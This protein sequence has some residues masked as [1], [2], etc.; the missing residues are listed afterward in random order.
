MLQI[1]VNRAPATIISEFTRRTVL[2]IFLSASDLV[3]KRWDEFLP[4]FLE[5][6]H[7]EIIPQGWI[8]DKTAETHLSVRIYVKVA[9][10]RD[11]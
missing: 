1:P 3:R 5:G 4:A 6:S 10:R 2:P 11:T 7:P 8:L 9:P